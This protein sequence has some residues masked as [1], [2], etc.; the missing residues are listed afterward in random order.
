[1]N[2]E[3]IIIE[4]LNILLKRTEPPKKQSMSVKEVQNLIKENE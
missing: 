2:K 3:D 4:K 1:M